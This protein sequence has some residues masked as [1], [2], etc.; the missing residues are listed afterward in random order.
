MSWMSSLVSPKLCYGTYS[1][2]IHTLVNSLGLFVFV[3]FL[4]PI[5][6]ALC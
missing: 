4:T 1:C 2:F 5:E 3:C 6:Q